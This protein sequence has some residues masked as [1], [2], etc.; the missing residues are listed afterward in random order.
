MIEIAD[1]LRKRA[2]PGAR[3][4]AGAI[5]HFGQSGQ[6]CGHKSIHCTNRS[7][8][9]QDL[10]VRLLGCVF[11][12]VVQ[13]GIGFGECLFD[14]DE[15][16]RE[17]VLNKIRRGLEVGRDLGAHVVLIRT[18]SLNPAGSYSPCR[19]NHTPESRQR[20]IQSLREVADKAES[21]DTTVVVE[22]HLLTIMDSPE[23]NAQ[24]LEAVGSKRM[25]VVMDYVNHFQTLDQV[26]DN[27]A[28]LKHIFDL[29]NPISIV[30][31][32]KDIKLSPGLV[33]HIDEEIP[34]EGELDLA[35]A[36]KLWHDAHPDD[37]M[38]LEHLPNEKYP[39]AA[40]NVHRI[41]ADAGISVY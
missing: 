17:R 32:V 22:T 39:Q 38:L 1:R 35:L 8:R 34:G 20:L 27:T 37:Y 16:V 28:R 12:T 36:L 40:A 23:T 11:Q 30:G 7:G 29:M 14:P 3:R 41:I 33:L 2:E 10:S 21:V 9:E 26:Y 15:E 25:K 4:L 18:G 6:P 31:H 13:F 5:P 19:D 24:V